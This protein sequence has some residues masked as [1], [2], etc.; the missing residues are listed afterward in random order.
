MTDTSPWSHVTT[1]EVMSA[2]TEFSEEL[3]VQLV[4]IERYT[5]AQFERLEQLVTT[6]CLHQTVS[7]D[8][9][10]PEIP[11]ASS[12]EQVEREAGDSFSYKLD[13]GDTSSCHSKIGGPAA[14]RCWQSGGISFYSNQTS[15]ITTCH[16]HA[17]WEKKSKV[18]CR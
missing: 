5:A 16:V 15:G 4:Q 8:Q 9:P 11:E 14:R 1:E 10:V 7:R 18:C 2:C 3:Q 13:D 12:R 6:F 17:E